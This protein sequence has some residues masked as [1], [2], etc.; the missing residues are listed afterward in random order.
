MPPVW[1]AAE[2]SVITCTCRPR[3]PCAAAEVP[4]STAHTDRYLMSV[5]VI[6]SVARNLLYGSR[7]CSGRAENEGGQRMERQRRETR[8][9][10]AKRDRRNRRPITVTARIQKGMGTK[11]E[12][13]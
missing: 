5:I 1:N 7:G 13:S 6:P 12:N 3:P 2:V 11:S 10:D 9:K 4:P 8:A